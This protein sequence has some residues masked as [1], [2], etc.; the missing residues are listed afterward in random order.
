M[1]EGRETV[2]LFSA[3]TLT[4][5]AATC[6]YV[7]YISSSAFRYVYLLLYYHCLMQTELEW[8]TPATKYSSNWING[9]G[10]CDCHASNAHILSG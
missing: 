9:N 8:R 10:S 2:C 5:T 6:R 4:L 3:I 1:Y 7:L